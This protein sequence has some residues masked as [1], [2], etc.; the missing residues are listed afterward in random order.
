MG[1]TLL[2]SAAL[3]TAA[4][5]SL[6]AANGS[7]SSASTSGAD[8]GNGGFFALF[9]AR[10]AGHG[11]GEGELPLNTPGENPAAEM[12]A[13]AADPN[14]L[15]LLSARDPGWL[16]ALL[17][18]TGASRQLN[19]EKTADNAL[20]TDTA[21]TDNSLSGLLGLLPPPPPPPGDAS[22]Q[23]ES[24]PLLD[25]GNPL[26]AAQ[27][28]KDSSAETAG[29]NALFGNNGSDTT[30]TLAAP[31]D[32]PA[33]FQAA[34]QQAQQLHPQRESRQ[35]DAGPPPLQTPIH[36]DKWGQEFG[37]RLVW[38]AKNDQ[39]VAQLHLN[40]PN[41]GPLQITLQL[42]ADQQATAVF[43]SPHA[44]VRQAVED[45]LPRLREMFAEAGLSLGQTNVGNQSFSQSGRETRPERGDPSRLHNDEAIL[46]SDSAQVSRLNVPTGLGGRGRVDLF[47]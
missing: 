8:A 14:A 27:L 7:E 36:Q 42:N 2:S 11:Q 15:P 9:A 43:N 34:L 47:A 21:P 23:G 29:L 16:Q 12:G 39:Q 20:T 4:N 30:A 13:S 22:A 45:A 38:M 6:A 19:G 17:G 18:Q 37:D 26:L 5:A 35:V 46:G 32:N 3:P 40:P 1:L 10:L 31:G 33:G 44:E 28:G 24:L 25:E 41:L